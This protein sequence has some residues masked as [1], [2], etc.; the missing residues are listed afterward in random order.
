MVG[1]FA[2]HHAAGKTLEVGCAL[3]GVEK[4]VGVGAQHGVARHERTRQWQGTASLTYGNGVFVAVS[5]NGSANR[6]MTSP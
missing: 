2:R 6:V 3:L 1:G 4:L 5:G